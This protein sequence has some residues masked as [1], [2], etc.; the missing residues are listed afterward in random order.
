M[1]TLRNDGTSWGTPEVSPYGPIPLEPSAVALNYGQSIFEGMKAY[2]ALS[3]EVVVFRP[4]ANCGRLHDGAE[5]Y[6]MA[7]V[8][9][10]GLRRR[11]P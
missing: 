9:A 11:L 6:A 4:W 10:P 3:G 7:P 2:R 8:P 1:V 5:R